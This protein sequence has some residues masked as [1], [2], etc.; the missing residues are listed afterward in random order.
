MSAQHLKELRAKEQMLTQEI[1]A[2]RKE[3][4]GLYERRRHTTRKI[5]DL[6]QSR[7]PT[8]ETAR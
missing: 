5:Q 2:K 6:E 3:L 8:M 4:Q 7:L 1:E